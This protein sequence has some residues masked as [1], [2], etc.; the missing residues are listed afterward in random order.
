MPQTEWPE[1]F[2]KKSPNVWKYSQNCNQNI[3][4]QNEGPKYLHPTAFDVEI[5]TCLETAYSAEKVPNMFK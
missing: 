5:S 3:K 1:K 4:A 2:N